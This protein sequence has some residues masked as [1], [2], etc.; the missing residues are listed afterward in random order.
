MPPD[1]LTH[2]ARLRLNRSAERD[3]LGREL[4]PVVSDR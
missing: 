4:P 3:E 2:D 1:V